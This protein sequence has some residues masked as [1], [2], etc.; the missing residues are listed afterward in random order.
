M[1]IS[2]QDFNP[3]D[4]KGDCPVIESKSEAKTENYTFTLL[5]GYTG[6]I[7]GAIPGKY[8]KAILFSNSKYYVITLHSGKM[9]N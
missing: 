4:C 6:T 3:E 8:Q 5:K 9:E 1:T 2:T 7:G